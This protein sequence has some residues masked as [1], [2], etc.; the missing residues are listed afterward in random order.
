MT[1][2]EAGHRTPGRYPDPP[3]DFDSLAHAAVRRGAVQKPAELAGLL[4]FLSAQHPRTIVEIGTFRGGTLFAWCRVAALDAT[5]ISIDLPGGMFGGGYSWLRGLT[6]RLYPKH[7]Q[8]LHLLRQNSHEAQTRDRVV[9][10]LGGQRADFLMIDGDHTYAGV[11]RD[12]ELYAPL[13]GSGGIIAF[14]DIL[15]HPRVA[16]VQV[17]RFWQEVKPRFPHVEF[18]DPVD[19]RG[20]GPWGGIGA[21]RYGHD[22]GPSQNHT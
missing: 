11:K 16:E 5:I 6:F 7:G 17:E 1:E 2:S 20:W 10:L 19:D 4:K 18:I 12:W 13:V 21:L 9:R 14:H 22:S 8:R 3:A 15:P